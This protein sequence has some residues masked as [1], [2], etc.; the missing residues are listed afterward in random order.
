MSKNRLGVLL[1][2]G[3]G[4]R[5][6]PITYSLSKQ[7]VPV[8][9]KPLFYYPLSNLLLSGIKDIL[10]ITNPEYLE[11]YKKFISLFKGY[12]LN[13][14]VVV[15]D[16]PR[17]LA[18]AIRIVRDTKGER[19]FCLMLGDNILF[20]NNLSNILSKANNSKKATLFGYY[21]DQPQEYGV[22]QFNKKKKISKII[23]KPSRYISNYISIGI[24]FY[25]KEVF[26]YFK[27]IKP[28]KRGELEI[29]DINNLYLKSNQAN[30]SFLSRG[31]SWFDI[32]RA[33]RFV[34]ASAF[35][36]SIENYQGLKI[37]CPEEILYRMGLVDKKTLIKQIKN[38]PDSD[39][40]TYL[41]KILK[42][43]YIEANATG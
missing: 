27:K 33:E 11:A 9:D 42:T 34:E 6:F 19:D 22:F 25:N 3:N 18:D 37:G 30:I 17:G 15:Q 5:F 36:R 40:K 43:Y 8:Y 23:E 31:I 12:G 2:G 7:L 13:I 29:T 10:I 24:Y 14:E 38:Y 21:I 20:G 1:S 32:G 35:I 28:S 26:K 39:Y 16:S 4:S 41:L